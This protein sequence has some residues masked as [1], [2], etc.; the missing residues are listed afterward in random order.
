VDLGARLSAAGRSVPATPSNEGILGGMR[1]LPL[2][3]LVAC[4]G[5]T[6]SGEP[7]PPLTS[8]PEDTGVAPPVQDTA[9]SDTDTGSPG[10]TDTEPVEE[11][12]IA[13]GDTSIDWV[14]DAGLG[15]GDPA[16]LCQLELSCAEP[17]VDDPK[18][19]CELSVTSGD[20]LL[21]YDGGAGVELRGRSSLGFPKP[22]YSVE[23]RGAVGSELLP[24]GSVWRYLDTAA[25]PPDTWADAAFDDSAWASGPAPLGYGDGQA[26]ALS[27]GP[28]PSAKP[29]TAWFRTTFAVADPATAGALVLGLRRDDGAVVYLNGVELRRDNLP[30]G[31][32]SSSTLAS[33]TVSG[34]EEA[35]YFE[36]GVPPELLVAGDNVLAVEVHQASRSSSDLTLD[37]F[38]RGEVE[39]VDVD[40]FGFGADSDWVLDGMYVDRAL[41]RNKLGYD[42]F[43]D[44]GPGNYAAESALCELS[45]NGSG[46]GVYR[47]TEKIKRDGGRVDIPADAGDGQSFL[48]KLDD[49]D[50]LVDNVGGSGTWQLSYPRAEDATPEQSAAITAVLTAWQSA[51]YGPDPAAIFDHMDMDSAVDVV[52]L[53]E[54]V[55]NVDGWFLSLYLYKEPGGKLRWVPWDVDLSLGQPSYADNESPE[56]FIGYRPQFVAGMGGDPAFRAALAARW[57]EL[58]KTTFSDAELL[59]RIDAQLATMGPAA[60]DNFSVWPIEDIEFGWSGEDYLYE[61]SSY[62]EELARVRAWIPAR[63]AWLDAHIGEW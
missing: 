6:L 12:A 38:V 16:L 57:V 29:I 8:S 62:D 41:V 18:I 23:L 63:T 33:V 42:L 2:V 52:L 7:D 5:G 20:G 43:R 35:V 10:E 55:K 46:V 25:P 28:D 15:V 34:G 19:E 21:L 32:L 3:L 11:T 30:A 27:Y 53:E 54:L 50:G 59:A 45:L 56:G 48:V 9:P 17:I 24:A 1:V 49:E 47:L 14:P 40:F 26:T 58:R 61:V 51:Y 37:A 36:T 22:Q 13:V 39:E 31:P 44:M 4:G 60:Y